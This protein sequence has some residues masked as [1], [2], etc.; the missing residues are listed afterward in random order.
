MFSNH[1]SAWYH[2]DTVRRNS[3]LVTHGSINIIQREVEET[4]LGAY[5]WYIK[6]FFKRICREKIWP[7]KKIY[8]SDAGCLGN[9]SKRVLR[10]SSLPD[11]SHG[12]S[13]QKTKTTQQ[14]RE[15]LTPEEDL[16]VR[17][18]MFSEFIKKGVTRVFTTRSISRFE[19]SKYKKQPSKKLLIG[20]YTFFKILICL[21]SQM[22]FFF[23]FL[24]KNIIIS[25]EVYQSIMFK[26]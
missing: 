24:L 11:L 22:I 23:S 26:G 16:R 9:L 7:Q 2:I 20:F 17:C 21:Q 3:V 1:L 13:F 10:E 25:S 8:G 15:D 5:S 12:L 19:F 4:S 6:K 18:R 14:K